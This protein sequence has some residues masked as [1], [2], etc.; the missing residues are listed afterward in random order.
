MSKVRLQKYFTDCGVMSRRAAEA[1]IRAGKVKI[2]GKVA[3]IG[4]QVEPMVDKVEYGGAVIIPEID[5]KI[6]IM[7]NKPRGYITTMSDD[8]GRK[9]V[10]SLVSDLGVRVYPIGRLDMESDG[11]LLL[12]NDGELA[13]RLTHPKHDIPKI[14]HVTVK[15]AVS[16]AAL[17]TLCTPLTIDGYKIRPVSAQIISV[18]PAGN[19]VLKMP[20]Y[21]GR[22]RQIRKMCDAAGLEV[23]KLSRVAVGNIELGKLASGKWRRLTKKEIAYLSAGTDMKGDKNA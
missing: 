16:A 12:T 17:N 10:S 3:R 15:G 18:T 8:K 23:K 9:T 20:L 5:E 11:L 13:N 7:L 21:E 1:E 2:N 19:T 14:Y 22:N 6:C 4:D